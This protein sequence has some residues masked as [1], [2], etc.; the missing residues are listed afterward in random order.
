MVGSKDM[1][2]PVSYSM[3]GGSEPMNLI[4]GR[5][6]I[7]QRYGYSARGVNMIAMTLL[8]D[9]SVRKA[10]LSNGDCSKVL[11]FDDAALATES[12]CASS[13]IDT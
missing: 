4:K 3:N 9:R 1:L 2:R 12:P 6:Q 7:T 8:P 10:Y 13:D 5:R 11:F